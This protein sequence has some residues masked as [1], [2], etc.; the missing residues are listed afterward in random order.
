MITSTR[1]SRLTRA[2][3][4]TLVLA[5]FALVL[6]GC[7]GSSVLELEV[8]DCLRSPDLEAEEVSTVE[9]LECSEPHDAEVYAELTFDGDEYPGTSTVQ[10]DSEEFCLAEFEPYVGIAYE[11]SEIYMTTMYPTEESWDQADDRTA[12]CILLPQED[13]TESLEG[14]AY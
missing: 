13:V 5:P 3:R 7:S 9:T 8:G 4:A 1:S 10:A 11:E 12:L 6:A 2:R 14:A